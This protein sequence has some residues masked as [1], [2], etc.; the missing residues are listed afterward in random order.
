[1]N[2][3][4]VFKHPGAALIRAT[5]FS[6]LWLVLVGLDPASWLIGGPVVI[7]AT[8]ASLRLSEPREHS[9]SFLGVLRFGPYFLRESLLGGIDVAARVLLPRMRVRPGIHLHRM[10][11]RNAS[12]R[13]LFIDSV[14]LVPGT[15]SA[16]LHG[17]LVTI[18]AL[19]VETDLERSLD[20]LER[21]VARVFG[22]T[23][24]TLSSAPLSVQSSPDEVF[25]PREP[26]R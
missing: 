2:R 19:D 15:L 23:L 7:A 20:E 11:L 14:S 4:L 21:R 13:V 16:D 17:D 1:M 5:L 6:L 18:H 8:I 3:R 9:L 12:A 26:R 25:Y 10:R 22:E 24:E